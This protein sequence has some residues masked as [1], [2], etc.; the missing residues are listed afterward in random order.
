MI[1]NRE[2]VPG[3]KHHVKNPENTTQIFN[4]YRAL[5]FSIAYRMLC[6][7]TDAEDI[8]QEAFVR[9]LQASDGEIQSPKAFLST[10]V[11]RLCIDQLRSARARRELYVGPW[12]P[13]PIPTDQR[14][15]LTETAIL[16]ESLSFAFLVMLESLGPLER[17]VFLLREVFDYDYAEIAAI[18]GKSEAYCRQVLHRAH[19]HLE[20]R[21][22]RFE[23]SREQQER[24]TSQFLDVSLGGD[25]QGLLNLLA[26]DVVFVADSG[27]KAWGGPKP[28]HGADNVA[29][30]VLGGRRFLPPGIQGG[31]EE[32]NGQPAIVGYDDGRPVIVLLLDIEGERIRNIYQVTNPDK[33]HGIRT[34]N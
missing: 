16:G 32:V 31:I 34:G 12:L 30:G 18:V 22:P 25:M 15:D 8:V 17:A 10:V 27:G 4:Q 2:D 26:D 33:L 9:W 19:Q 13:E 6:N 24:I 5:L 23:V 3:I 21:R 7:A 28:V 29:R 14:Q 11:T 1:K 20:Q